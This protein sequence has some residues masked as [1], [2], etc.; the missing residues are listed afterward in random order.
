MSVLL[1]DA[2]GGYLE[3]GAL[4][5]MLAWK[6]LHNT[7]DTV[8]Q[9]SW[10]GR[11]L[12]GRAQHLPSPEGARSYCLRRCHYSRITMLCL[13]VAIVVVAVLFLLVLFW[14]CF[15]F[16]VVVV[17]VAVCCCCFSKG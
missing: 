3:G 8:L 2:F 7:E 9:L 14:F 13:V 16:W 6:A 12:G 4:K 15:F 10:R 11:G 17:V 5:T 1:W